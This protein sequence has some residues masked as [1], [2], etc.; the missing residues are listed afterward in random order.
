MAQH[1][2]SK[3]FEPDSIAVF[4]AGDDPRSMGSVVFGNLVAG[5]YDGR[6]Y[7]INKRPQGPL[8]N[9]PVYASLDEVPGPVD[10]ALIATPADTVPNIVEACG[11]HGVKAAIVL[12]AGF[13]EAGGRGAFLQR[14]IV[15]TARR[16]RLRLLG[17]K[18]LGVVR[19]GIGLNAA[20]AQGRPRVG[21]LALIAQSSAICASVLDWAHTNDV[22]FSTVMS[23]GT[24]M[25]LDFG[26]VL[27]YL[28]SDHGT[29]SILLQVERL[30]DARRFLSALR[31]AAR[32]K[33]VI[34]VKAGRSTQ[35]AGECADD[36]FDAVLARAGV[37]RVTTIGD[38]FSAARVLA[39]ARRPQGTRLAVVA[40]GGGPGVMA[41]DRAI[42]VGVSMAQL[43]PATIA[44]LDGTQ[45]SAWSRGNP[46]NVL[47]DVTNQRYAEALQACLQDPGVDGVLAVVC[48]QSIIEPVVLARQVIE[49]SES[50][51]KPLLACWMGEVHVKESRKLFNEARVPSFRAP[52][53]AVDA[54]A[55]L[56]RHF[57]NRANLLQTPGALSDHEPPDLEGTRLIVETALSERRR[58]LNELECKALLAAFRIPVN[59]FMVARSANEA[60]LFA[61]QLGFPV[62]MKVLSPDIEHRADCGGTMLNLTSALAVRTAYH[63][64]IA[65]LA[66]QHPGARITGVSVERMVQRPGGREFA[67]GI[68]SDPVCGPVVTL[69]HGGTDAELI[70]ERAVA[71]PPLNRLLIDNMLN[72]SRMAPFLAPRRGK[73]G[74][75]RDALADL[76]Q[77]V[78]EMACELP[79]LS[80]LTI[81]PCIVDDQG[82]VVIGARAVVDHYPGQDRYRHMAICPYPSHRSSPWQLA[83]GTNLFI[84]PI[85]PEDAELEQEF[86]RGLSERARYSRFQLS[87]NE[88]TPPMLARFTQIDYDREM[89]LVAEAS[90]EARPVLVGESRYVINPDGETCEFGLVVADAWRQ[91]GIGAKL[92]LCLADAA[93]ER[94]L[95]SIHGDV[96]QDNIGMRRL[97]KS[98]GYTEE[99]GDD[100]SL[101]V[102]SKM[103]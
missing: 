99:P 72:E 28:I 67:I 81:N 47:G 45:R 73:P 58:V 49:L 40:N 6:V 7:V 64:I 29:R 16:Y 84:R 83:D 43:A 39:G 103:L 102:V 38:L 57:R 101:V 94:G 71:L 56:A 41:A 24:G 80:E 14:V 53:A 11:K 13:A 8:Q 46:V 89:A 9:R 51:E 75:S 18:A 97:M 15:D 34:A 61:E 26:D 3:L 50:T 96:L 55:F 12:S 79:W 65:A 54:F 37:V 86:V 33:P 88:L 32:I 19:P 87:L 62:A 69:G 63:D 95:K 44:A 1:Y 100:D 35:A 85:R 76:L 23:I 2:L 17:A 74:L 92:M 82:A 20:V 52:E 68:I 59:G 70:S 4:G 98:L 93:R 48:P 25:D 66:R 60:L 77:R 90:L 21:D 36:V 27:D 78:S 5:G 42:D 30:R 31:A 22:G 10:L 91:R